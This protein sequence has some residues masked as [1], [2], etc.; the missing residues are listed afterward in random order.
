MGC[1]LSTLWQWCANKKAH[2][3]LSGDG[4]IMHIGFSVRA[5]Q[6]GQDRLGGVLEFDAVR[7]S[8]RH[9]MP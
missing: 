1:L 8:E 6:L 3:S 9:H 5:V 7:V 4:E 2:T